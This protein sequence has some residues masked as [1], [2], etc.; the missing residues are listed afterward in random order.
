MSAKSASALDL[1]AQ[2]DLF[3]EF[4]GH[5]K[6][7]YISNGEMLHRHITLYVSTIVVVLSG[8]MGFLLTRQELS[9]TAAVVFTLAL[10]MVAVLGVLAFVSLLGNLTASLDLA[11]AMNFMYI[12]L[13]DCNA[14]IGLAVCPVR[15]P[16]S[17][18]WRHFERHARHGKSERT[19]GDRKRR[20]GD[21]PSR[22][23]TRAN[24]LSVPAFS[25]NWFRALIVGNA[26]LGF[27]L[28]SWMVTVSRSASLPLPTETVLMA[29][30]SQLAVDRWA[31]GVAAIVYLGQVAWSWR[32]RGK[33]DDGLTNR[34]HGF[35][36][37]YPD[38]PWVNREALE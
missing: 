28:A 13:C 19:L 7:L 4:L 27:V 36:E 22:I 24:R 20:L 31:G 35:C 18:L 23:L 17:W 38:L 12:C 1:S 10:I 37:R 14:K 11:G 33:A 25:H 6:D 26:L 5:F 3:V 29:W 8:A 16:K 32:A 30:R 9:S 21:W 15:F 2:D 34:V